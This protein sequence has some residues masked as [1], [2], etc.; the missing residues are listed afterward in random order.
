MRSKNAIRLTLLIAAIVM[1]AIFAAAP[2]RGVRSS[3]TPRDFEQ[4]S[5]NAAASE[6]PASADA[7]HR[8]DHDDGHDHSGH[9]ASAT[10]TNHSDAGFATTARAHDHF[11]PAVPVETL[12]RIARENPRLAASSSTSSEGLKETP[13]PG[14]GVM[15]DLESRFQSVAIA[16]VGPDGKI[17]FTCVTDID[18]HGLAS[19]NAAGANAQQTNSPA[20]PGR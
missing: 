18:R 4:V 19:T 13:L 11:H 10:G 16:T 15:V 8:H 2:D 3:A 6:K 5:A 9:G 14:G 1:I 7:L 20:P 12:A 17:G